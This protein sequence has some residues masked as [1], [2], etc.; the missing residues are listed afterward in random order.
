MKGRRNRLR[1]EMAFISN[2][3]SWL[4]MFKMIEAQHRTE[5]RSQHEQH[6]RLLHEMQK[7]MARE[8]SKQQDTL[9]HSLSAHREVSELQLAIGKH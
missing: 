2:Q 7:N 1:V 9:K 8:L 6:E 4:D 5:L 3:V